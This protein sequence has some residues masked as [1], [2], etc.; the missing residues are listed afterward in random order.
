MMS[1]RAL[2]L[3]LFMLPAF[4][5]ANPVS[6]HM[7]SPADVQERLDTVTAFDAGRRALKTPLA[8]LLTMPV[9]RAMWAG[10]IITDSDWVGIQGLASIS[11]RIDPGGVDDATNM[12]VYTC[13]G[14]WV[15]VGHVIFT[16][17]AYKAMY[18]GLRGNP[19]VLLGLKKVMTPEEVQLYVD[20]KDSLREQLRDLKANRAAPFENPRMRTLIARASE[21]KLLQQARMLRPRLSNRTV[22]RQVSAEVDAAVESLNAA[23]RNNG[24]L[25]D[26]LYAFWTG[27]FTIRSSFGIEAFQ[28]RDKDSHTPDQWTGNA[29]SAW[30]FEDLPSN[31]YGIQLATQLR[32][33]IFNRGVV[34]QV[35]RELERMFD[36]F[37]GV[38]LE[39]QIRVN[40]C[41]ST[42]RQVLAEDAD[43][44]SHLASTMR[45]TFNRSDTS[46]PDSVFGYLSTYKRT[47]QH[48]CVCDSNGNPR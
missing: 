23:A 15:D 5:L 36:D 29:T 24:D 35:K 46:D 27:Y 30:T 3:G 26:L 37:G 32:G 12:F 44:Y 10:Q 17:L 9:V 6:S 21:I 28:Q 42:A 31:F 19:L 40:G 34:N 2:L 33:R 1:S 22:R 45:P 39:S 11:H 13:R 25:K 38:D 14:G 41:S 47:R 18:Q 43:Y 8:N 20:V 48:R 4:A 7:G 16:A